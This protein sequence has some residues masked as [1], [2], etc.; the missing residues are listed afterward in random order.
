MLRS[1]T[2]INDNR[3]Y[4]FNYL[5]NTGLLTSRTELN[6]KITL[7]NYEKNGKLK[8]IIEPNSMITNITY[9]I[10]SSGIVTVMSKSDLNIETWITNGSSTYIYKSMF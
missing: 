9:F 1:L 3:S 8:E 6:E 2:T 5:G 4:T 7:F 10:N